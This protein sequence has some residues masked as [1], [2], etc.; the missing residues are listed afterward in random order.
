MAL[1][2][3]ERRGVP[4]VNGH[5]AFRPGRMYVNHIPEASST[6][7]PAV[8]LAVSKWTTLVFTEKGLKKTKGTRPPDKLP[9]ATTPITHKRTPNHPQS[10]E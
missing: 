6:R 2:D 4:V 9:S 8:D 10:E 5:N 1:D 7:A 3:D